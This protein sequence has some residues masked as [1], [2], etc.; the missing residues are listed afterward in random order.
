MIGTA[1]KYV[2]GSP[3]HD[4]FSQLEEH[5]NKIISNNNK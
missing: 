1:W 2:T 4:D 5:V 3:D